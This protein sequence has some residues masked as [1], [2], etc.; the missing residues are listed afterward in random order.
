MEQASGRQQK[1]AIQS[2]RETSY[3]LTRESLRRNIGISAHI[4][5][6]KTTLTERILF[7]TGRIR[8]IHE[9][10]GKDGVGATMDFM[11]LER[12]KGITIQSAATHCV[13]KDH[14]INIIDTPG[15]VDFTI[16]VE[17]ALRVLDGAILVLC[18]VSG[19]Q[20]QSLTVDRQ[21][22]RYSVPRLTFVNKLDRQG[23][24]PW[25]IISQVTEK[26]KIPAAAVQIPLGLESEIRGLVDVITG[27]TIRFEGSHGEVVVREL[28]QLPSDVEALVLAKR[29]QLIE[30]LADQDETLGEKFLMES[31]ITEQD[32]KAAIRRATLARKFSPVFMG[33]ALKNLGVQTLLDGV[34]DYLPAPEL[35]ENLALRHLER[36]G[37]VVEESVPLLS[38]PESPLVA[39]AFKLEDGRFG[40]LTYLRVY[41]GTLRKG[42]VIVNAR[43]G[44]KVKIP[45]LVRMH[46]DDMEDITESLAGDICA[47]FGLECASGDTFISPSLVDSKLTLESLFVPDP[48][49]SLA[50]APK[51]RE[52]GG[53]NFAR[54]LSRFSREDPTFRVHSDPESKETIISGMGELHLDIYL[55]RMKREFD[56]ECIS[57]APRV[58][59][60]ETV[61]KRADYNYL[62]K[63]QSGGSGQF[64]G[65]EGYIEPSDDGKTNEFVNAVIGN[66]IPPQFF[67]AVEKGFHEAVDS[68]TLAGYPIQGVRF[69]LT[70]GRAHSV[71]S[72]ELAFRMA[73]IMAMRQ[74]FLKADAGILEPIMMV[75]VQVPPEFQGTIT[76]SLSRRRGVI[77]NTTA[78]SDYVSIDAEVPLAEMFGYSTEL[79]SF[80]Q[81]KGEFSMEFRR[82]QHVPSHIQTSLVEGH[83]SAKAGK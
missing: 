10:R 23:A 49:M 35:V 72:N 30:T 56:V 33:T 36:D 31:E 22:K 2:I 66:N 9:V 44:K 71:D 19:V 75:E 29:T 52:A 11:D 6:G 12:E 20:S 54:A 26:L 38:S 53:G 83:A 3:D 73:T 4:D 16:E 81:G 65:V 39:L 46:A 61:F 24:N 68:G 62:H 25:R 60:R 17:R 15:H 78:D 8:V 42:D 82:H 45:R 67:P 13:W 74:A 51:K 64:A 37:S 14:G 28:I 59:Y 7:Y 21:M 48:V 41:Q 32:I 76:G 55:E 18:G 58:N 43:T 1:D 77:I 50:V 70:D 79:R 69:V 47:I 27:E 63:K 40:Q 57:G 34:V 5:S 80:T